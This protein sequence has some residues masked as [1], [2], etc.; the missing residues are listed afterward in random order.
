MFKSW[1]KY[2]S[3]F[4][5]GFGFCVVLHVDELTQ[6][7]E[8][9][10]NGSEQNE[11]MSRKLN[12]SATAKLLITMSNRYARFSMCDLDSTKKYDIASMFILNSML[13]GSM[14]VQPDEI[15]KENFTV[16]VSLMSLLKQSTSGK[17]FSSL[18]AKTEEYRA[19]HLSYDCNKVSDVVDVVSEVC[20]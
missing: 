1:M 4:A 10:A 3:V 8:I 2:L 16:S 7:E 5:L 11:V 15:H 12:H 13:L 20:K 17:L 6:S 18:L 19:E 9:S 14:T